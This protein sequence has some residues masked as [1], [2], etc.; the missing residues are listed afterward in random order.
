MLEIK[1]NNLCLLSLFLLTTSCGGGINNTSEKKVINDKIQQQAEIVNEPKNNTLLST[2]DKAFLVSFES[3]NISEDLLKTRE[4]LIKNKKPSQTFDGYLTY[5]IKT[6]FC[7]LPVKEIIFGVCFKDEPLSK[8]CSFIEDI[9]LILDSDFNKAVDHF[10][11]TKDID[12][13]KEKRSVFNSKAD[14]PTLRPL[15]YKGVDGST[16]LHCDT[17]G[18]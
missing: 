18:L 14:G 10:K 15:L 5:K 4:Y 11:S 6:S 2:I 9:A 8:D 16:V 13:T 7:E 12:F 1:I 17:G 3:C